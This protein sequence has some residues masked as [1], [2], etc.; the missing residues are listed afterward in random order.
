MS[1]TATELNRAVQSAPV[2]DW[3]HGTV[4][5]RGEAAVMLRPQ[6]MAVLKLLHASAGKIVTK[7]QVM[8]TVWPDVA[9]TDDSLVQCITE[10]RKAFG[11]VDHSIVKTLPKRGYLYEPRAATKETPPKTKRG[12]WLVALGLTAAVGISILAMT[13][14]PTLKP[15][16]L[17]VIA[18]LPFKNLGGDAIGEKFAG[19]MTE[20]VITDLSHAKNFAVIA[21]SSSDV[22]RNQPTDITAIGK[23]LDAQMVLKG[24]LE[25]LPGRIRV[26]A[27]LMD[28]QTG[29]VLWS[30]RIEK[31]ST[32]IFAIES[33]ITGRI[34]NLVGG[35]GGAA[36]SFEQSIIR[37][38]PPREW[39]AYDYYQLGIEAK[40]QYNP[41]AFQRAEE[42]L[43]ES[44]RIDPQFAR[45]Y[46][47][48]AWVHELRYW[49]GV[50]SI[51]VALPKM[52]VAA[53]RAAE[54][55]PNDGEVHAALA[56]A[57]SLQNDFDQEQSEALR[58][59][60]LA[61]NNADVL[62]LTSQQLIHVDRAEQASE[63]VKKALHLNPNFP[64]WYNAFAYEALFYGREFER[65]FESAKMAVSGDIKRSD[66]IALS[67]A[68]LDKVDETRSAKLALEESNPDWSVEKWFS[69]P[70]AFRGEKEHQLIFTAATKAGLRICMTKQEIETTQN[71]FHL[72]S[73]D[74]ERAKTIAELLQQ[75]KG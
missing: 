65:S 15:A 14:Q 33:E 49:F 42:L 48:L 67:A 12:I 4:S 21:R 27:Q 9:V 74:T 43:N 31:Q 34:A 1:G 57:Y 25:P 37:R 26:T 62:L 10:I 35:Y 72:R 47:G 59:L 32:D 20:D 50:E 56:E 41:A 3:L 30:D 28:A 11:D 69:G 61:P 75:S 18:V 7:D 55:D 73:C 60:E 63:N 45:A 24:S 22:Y 6:S 29:K 19:M 40:H 36:A 71:A 5:A 68:M 52:L 17:P 23:A 46:L 44:I 13:N 54:L 51:D 8:A 66:I 2:I 53:K 58:A 70:A 38:K 39:S 16:Q 64:V